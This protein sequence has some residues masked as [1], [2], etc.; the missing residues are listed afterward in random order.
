MEAE[1]Q[2]Q[3]VEGERQRETETHRVGKRWPKAGEGGN[4]GDM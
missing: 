3:E 2:V 1:M 4:R